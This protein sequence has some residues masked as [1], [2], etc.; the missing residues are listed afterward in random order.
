MAAGQQ[1]QTLRR[2]SEGFFYS[3][4]HS[5]HPEADSSYIEVSWSGF[6]GSQRCTDRM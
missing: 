6:L 5:T 4:T 1:I 2:M 3:L